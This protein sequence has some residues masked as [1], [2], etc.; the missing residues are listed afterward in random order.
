V[1][2]AFLVETPFYLVAG[3]PGGRERLAGRRLPVHLIAAAILP[4]LVCCSGAIQFRWTSLGILLAV[5]LV[6]SFWYRVLPPHPAVDLAYITLAGA[7]IVSG[8]L[9]TVYPPFH[10]IPLEILGHVSVIEIVILVMMLERQVP[11]TGFGFVPSLAE[12]RIGAIHFVYF[13]ALAAPL[14]L[15]LK[16]T[17]LVPP[18]PLW[19]VAASFLGALWFQALSEEFLFRGLLQPWMETWTRHRTLA[20]FLTA[21]IFGL[22]HYRLRGWKWTILV[23]ILGWACGRARNQSGGIR[24]GAVTHSLVIAAWRAFFW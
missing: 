4:Y 21:A 3:F 14:N 23:A 7:I 15:L 10:K 9:A 2:A 24:A 22:I 5:A 13:L 8:M 17:H 12:W 6:L 11:E 19:S 20:L 1:I 18:R 16:A